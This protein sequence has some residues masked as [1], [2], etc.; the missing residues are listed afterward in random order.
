MFTAQYILN[1]EY[2]L[3]KTIHQRLLILLFLAISSTA[4]GAPFL[5]CE[6]YPVGGPQPTKFLITINGKTYE[7]TPARTSEGSVYLKYDI[8]DFPDGIYTGTAIA[9]GEKGAKYSTVTYSFK[10]TGL[11]VEP[12]TPPVPKQKTPP[13]RYYEGHIKMEGE[14]SQ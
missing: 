12:Y 8:G 1:T 10:K 6:P 14:P 9:V 13:S 2:D 4:F 7:S 5:V 3:M 11:K